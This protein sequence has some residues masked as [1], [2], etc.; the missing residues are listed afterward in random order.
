[1]PSRNHMRRAPYRVWLASP[2]M[3]LD[4]RQARRQAQ[5]QARIRRRRAGAGVAVIAIVGAVVAIALASS[6]GS[7]DAPTP[8][9]STTPVTNTET[10]HVPATTRRH[11]TKKPLTWPPTTAPPASSGTGHPGTAAVPVLM[12]H[13]IANPLPGVPY[14]GLYVPVAE[15]KQ[16][17]KALKDAGWHAV[18]QD[19]LL[20]HWRHGASRGKGKPIVLTFDNG[21]HSQ[22][23]V[24]MPV[25]RKYHWA[26]VENI[27]LTGL[28]P[29]QGGLT[30]K[31]VKKLLHA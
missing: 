8:H 27:Q 30:R 14:P 22:A 19:Q 10:T 12:Y 24:A 2:R 20:A 4:E 9:G 18:P 16:Q 3:D 17:M 25:L 23:A 6:G 13:V 28:P 5:R 29:S 21:Y 11:H 26:G 15:F 7:N 31:E 1:S